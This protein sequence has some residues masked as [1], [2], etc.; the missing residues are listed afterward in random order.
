MV[1]LKALYVEF[2]SNLLHKLI[3]DGH[4]HVPQDCSRHISRLVQ[5]GNFWQHLKAS[6]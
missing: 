2:L 6:G 5:L 1:I 4:R 3:R